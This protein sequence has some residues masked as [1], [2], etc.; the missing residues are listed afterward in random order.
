MRI[1]SHLLK[2]SLNQQMMSNERILD[3]L[4]STVPDQK[5]KTFRPWEILMLFDHEEELFFI[6]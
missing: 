2:K 5:R 1:W 4:V 6:R 3:Q